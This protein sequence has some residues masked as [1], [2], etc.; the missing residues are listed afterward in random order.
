M[1]VHVCKHVCVCM[2][3]RVCVCVC[4][5]QGVLH[6]VYTSFFRHMCTFVGLTDFVKYS[7]L[8][9][10]NEILLYRNYH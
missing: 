9:L 2:R 6:Y 4:C 7:V 1:C 10:V 5:V 3:A 8:I